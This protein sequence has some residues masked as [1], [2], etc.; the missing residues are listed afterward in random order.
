MNI[1]PKIKHKK[2]IHTA[3]TCKIGKRQE[4]LQSFFLMNGKLLRN[5]F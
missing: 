1:T 5:S 2:K 3:V 4:T